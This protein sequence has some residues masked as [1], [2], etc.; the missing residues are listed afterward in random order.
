MIRYHPNGYI[1][2]LVLSIR[3]ATYLFDL[4]DKWG[5]HVGVVVTF[6]PLK[7]HAQAFEAH[8]GI[9]ML[10][11]KLFQAGIR[12]AVV[13]HENEVPHF[14]YQRMVLV[15][16][17]LSGNLRSFFIRTDIDMDLATGTTGTLV[18]H[19]PEIV[20]LVP[21]DD[22]IRGHPVLPFVLGL[23]IPIKSIRLIALEDRHIESVLVNPELLR[24]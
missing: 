1:L 20:L 13:L 19:F 22:A 14:N 21:I 2:L 5:K 7:H 17:F 4:P 11:R 3:A 24:K 6:Y 10:G 9:Y 8:S 15:H 12:L 18:T 23:C 16:Q